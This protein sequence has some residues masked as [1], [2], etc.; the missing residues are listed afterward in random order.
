MIYEIKVCPDCR[1]QV[2]EE[3]GVSGAHYFYCRDLTC[4][5]GI[6]SKPI[7]YGLLKI[8]KTIDL[9]AEDAE[10][11]LWLATPEWDNKPEP[12][13]TFFIQDRW[14]PLKSRLAELQRGGTCAQA[15]AV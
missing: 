1:H 11:L 15:D 3:E 14:E 9:D 12:P 10:L 2:V 13:C 4:D 5:R 8:I 6:V 7:E